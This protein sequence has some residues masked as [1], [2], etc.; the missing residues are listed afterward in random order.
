MLS[1]EFRFIRG[2]L[3]KQ[4]ATVKKDSINT[5]M[6]KQMIQ[7]RLAGAGIKI[8]FVSYFN[9][10]RKFSRPILDESF[11]TGKQRGREKGGQLKKRRSKPICRR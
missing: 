7:A 8:I 4:A 9:R 10:Q 6:T 5:C 2:P 1:R 3:R 11:E